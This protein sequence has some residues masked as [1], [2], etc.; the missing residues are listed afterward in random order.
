[1]RC[2]L[3]PSVTS[4]ATRKSLEPAQADWRRLNNHAS[5]FITQAPWQWLSD[6]N[7]FAVRD[8]ET[9]EVAYC[10]ILGN[11]GI[12]YGLIAYRGSAGLEGYALIVDDAVEKDEFLLIQDAL[13]FTLGDRE[14][15][16]KDD[17][18]VHAALGL[19]FRGRGAWPIFRSHRPAYLPARL[20]RSECRMLTTCLEQSVALLDQ[21]LSGELPS[22][23]PGFEGIVTRRAGSKGEW[24]TAFEPLPDQPALI[25]VTDELLLQRVL[26]SCRKVRQSWEVRVLPVGSFWPEDGGSPFV[27]R[28]L[29]CVDH[30]SGIVFGVD[31][32]EPQNNLPDAF[33]RVTEK[34][35]FIPETLR[36]T[37]AYLERR[38]SPA[39]KALEVTIRQVKR[40]PEIE[41]VSK[42]LKQA[43]RLGEPDF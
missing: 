19:K 9:G 42:S 22:P 26:R 27:G 4:A 21:A 30:K 16:D 34:A 43:L 3:C 1:M 33:L 2:T 13:A 32:L 24:E 17:R 15:V 41:R 12:E 11:G 37:S 6:E 25:P 18:A 10:C 39:A 14:M 28:I 36:V 5:R 7:I 38:L 31:I 20:D 23:P 35:G 8:P 29:L 40:L